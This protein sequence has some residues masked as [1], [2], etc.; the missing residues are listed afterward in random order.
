MNYQLLLN[1]LPEE[2]MPIFYETSLSIEAIKK[3][4]Y[5]LIDCHYVEID[6]YCGF[7]DFNV[8]D[9]F[10]TWN[11][12]LEIKGFEENIQLFYLDMMKQIDKMSGKTKVERLF[13]MLSLTKLFLTYPIITT[14]PENKLLL[15]AKVYETTPTIDLVITERMIWDR[16]YY[17]EIKNNI[18]LGETEYDR[19]FNQKLLLEDTHELQLKRTI[20]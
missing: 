2:E 9:L 12:M 5:Q 16:A 10:D 18:L 14:Y 13:L 8:D 20:N 19:V 11:E 1:L 3:R 17:D 6:E 4:L 7:D 15:L